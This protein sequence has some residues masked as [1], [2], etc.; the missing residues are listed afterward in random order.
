MV[1]VNATGPETGLQSCWYRQHRSPYAPDP[2]EPDETPVSPCPNQVKAQFHLVQRQAE[3]HDQL[4][5]TGIEL[6][7][8]PW[9]DVLPRERGGRGQL[10]LAVSES[11]D[12][13][14]HEDV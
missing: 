6:W 9:A 13:H 7:L 11:A 5:L 2:P 12:F 10:G 8:R 3:L 4:T 1:A 14:D